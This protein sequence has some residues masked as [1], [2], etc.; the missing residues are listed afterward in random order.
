MAARKVV[1]SVCL[2]KAAV[3]PARGAEAAEGAL[4]AHMGVAAMSNKGG[5]IGVASVLV[6]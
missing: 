2:S 6:L 4:R 1:G 5:A 3:V